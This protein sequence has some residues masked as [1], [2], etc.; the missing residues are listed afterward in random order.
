VPPREWGRRKHIQKPSED[1]AV[2]SWIARRSPA[3][4]HL[5]EG[6]HAHYSTVSMEEK[7]DAVATVIDLAGYR[8]AMGK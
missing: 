7:S 4:N 1:V 6:M 8:E 3:A 2:R 5:D